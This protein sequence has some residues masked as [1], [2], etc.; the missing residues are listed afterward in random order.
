MSRSHSVGVF[1]PGPTTFCG[2]FLP[3]FSYRSPGFWRGGYGIPLH[4]KTPRQPDLLGN[5]RPLNQAL[6]LLGFVFFVL[7][8]I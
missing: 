8:T 2:F 5:W 7:G 4:G 1:V 6:F 3:S